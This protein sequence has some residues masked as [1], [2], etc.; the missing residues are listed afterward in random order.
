[1]LRVAILGDKDTILPFKGSG[2]EAILIG[3]P[4][5]GGEKLKQLAA[6]D[7]GIIFVSESVAQECLDVIENISEK[8]S[9][10]I[11]TIVPDFREG[12]TE[13]AEKRLRKLIR[14]AV[15]MDIY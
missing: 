4:K 6:K 15:G 11:I 2:I 13:V 1:M 9:F 8:K 14:K 3:G 10:P 5:G 12:I 7:Y